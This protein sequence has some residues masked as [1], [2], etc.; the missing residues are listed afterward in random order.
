[1]TESIPLR[2]LSERREVYRCIFDQILQSDMY[3]DG[4]ISL[5][6]LKNFIQLNGV[7]TII[8]PDDTMRK[9]YMINDKEESRRLD[10]DE[11]VK[12]M[13]NKDFRRTINNYINS[14]VHF[15]IPH[16]K[17]VHHERVTE[18][19][20]VRARRSVIQRP[21]EVSVT[22]SV[23]RIGRSARIPQEVEYSCFPPPFFLV[24]ISILEAACF[25]IDEKTKSNTS[26][27]LSA[28]IFIYDPWKRQEAWRFFT[29]MLVHIGYEHIF[30][31]LIVQLVLGLPLEMV[32]QWKRVLLI[33]VAGVLAGSLAHSVV[34]PNIML[35]GASGGVYSIMTAHIADVIMNWS[36]T[37]YPLIQLIAFS[38]IICADLGVTVYERYFQHI[39]TNVGVAA[40]AG[41]AAAGLL[42]G[43]NVLRNFRVTKVERYLW[44]AALITYALLMGGA[45][46]INI[47][48]PGY[49][50]QS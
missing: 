44:W 10:F 1:M 37:P 4:R 46:M 21:S 25:A 22:D 9:I 38:I 15:L 16:P 2:D 11:F 23:I 27:G 8:L 41:G 31:N 20:V 42:V 29:Y 26:L 40:H 32:H 24:M 36:V 19:I 30:T 6:D 12:F 34:D 33:Y 48:W 28:T 47:F 3:N 35:G 43:I 49:F 13:E 5:G 17:R 14:Y 50:H 18:R 7:E 39:V 45:I